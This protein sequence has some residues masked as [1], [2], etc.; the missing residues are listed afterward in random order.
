MTVQMMTGMN[1]VAFRLSDGR[2]G[3][4]VPSGAPICLLTTTGRNT[5]RARTVPL[6][7]IWNDDDMIVV[8]SNGGSNRL[9]AWYLN[10]RADPSVDVSVDNWTQHRH[11]RL[12]A[13]DERSDYWPVLVDAYVHFD[14]YDIRTERE[15]PLVV[16]EPRGPRRAM[17]GGRIAQ[18]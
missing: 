1:N 15:I 17:H 16:L 8:A 9:P 12:A 5:G 7:F 4:H 6:L 13:V 11:A 3:G 18:Q 10:L 14:N 2:V